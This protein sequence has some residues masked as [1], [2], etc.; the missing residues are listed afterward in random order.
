MLDW[1]WKR[2]RGEMRLELGRELRRRGSGGR[3]ARGGATASGRV[4]RGLARDF[5]SGYFTGQRNS[6]ARA[7]RQGNGRWWFVLREE[8]WWLVCSERKVLLAG[9][10]DKPSEHAD[11]LHFF[12]ASLLGQV[13]LSSARQSAPLRRTVRNKR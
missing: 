13:M 6:A 2:W 4:P 7:R 10:S 9:G 8:Y 1:K 11:W 3:V 5:A 12:F